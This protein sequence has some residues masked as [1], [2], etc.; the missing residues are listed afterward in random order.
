MQ[1][2]GRVFSIAASV[3]SIA[4]LFSIYGLAQSP[5]PLTYVI[6]SRVSGKVLDVPGYSTSD[7]ALIQ[8]IADNGGLNQEFRLEPVSGGYYKIVSRWSGK[9]LDVPDGSNANNVQI[10]QFT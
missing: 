9:A 4:L 2:Q 5:D 10:Q 6:K 8:Q 7:H 1:K 3:L